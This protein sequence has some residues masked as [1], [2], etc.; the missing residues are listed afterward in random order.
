MKYCGILSDF[1]GNI[2]EF[3][4]FFAV[5]W[6]SE[7]PMSPSISYRGCCHQETKS[8]R[9][10]VWKVARRKNCKSDLGDEELKILPCLIFQLTVKLK[11]QM[12]HETNQRN[13]K[14]QK[15]K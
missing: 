5:F 1:L 4:K 15:G 10:N 12:M 2:A 9:L 3:A 7:P 11:L 14:Q 6:C 8:F 13:Q